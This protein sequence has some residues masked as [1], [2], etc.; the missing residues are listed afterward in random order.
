MI[1]ILFLRL[2]YNLCT[3]FPGRS[4]YTL[5]FLNLLTLYI[6]ILLSQKQKQIIDGQ[7]AIYAKYGDSDAVTPS[8]VSAQP[9]FQKLLIRIQ[10][11]DRK[12]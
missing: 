10:S 5:F 9:E 6:I 1:S 8:T 11:D 4:S 12:V 3:F 7:S 2:E